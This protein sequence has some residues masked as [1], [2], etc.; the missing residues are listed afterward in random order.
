M[1]EHGL[2]A[3][4]HFIAIIFQADNKHAAQPKNVLSAERLAGCERNVL[5]QPRRG[6]ADTAAC[7]HGRHE[8]PAE[9]VA[10][11]PLPGRDW[12]WINAAIPFTEGLMGLL[13]LPISLVLFISAP[14][15]ALAPRSIA[16]AFPLPCL[17][18][19]VA[20]FH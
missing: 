1:V 18:D 13:I 11:Q 10:K 9:H 8:A 17:A 12:T 19:I 4:L 5:Q 7:D 6:L 3:A 20:E 14:R 15:L 16:L 2:D